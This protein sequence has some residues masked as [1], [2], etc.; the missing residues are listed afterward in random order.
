MAAF[1]PQQQDFFIDSYTR[2]FS[3]EYGKTVYLTA[4]QFDLLYFLYVH[5]GQVFTKEQLYEKVWGYEDMIEGRNLT[6]FIRKLRKT[7]LCN[8]FGRICLL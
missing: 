7:G 5:K 3:I 8:E 4:K 1:E 2:T 6:S